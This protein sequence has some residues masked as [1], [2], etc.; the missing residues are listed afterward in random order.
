M[1]GS[2]TPK[3]YNLTPFSIFS[4]FQR[5]TW[6]RASSWWIR[7]A[8][9]KPSAPSW[10]A[11]TSRTR[12]WRTPTPT[13]AR[14]PAACT[15]WASCCTSRDIR[16]WGPSDIHVCSRIILHAGTLICRSARWCWSRCF[17]LMLQKAEDIWCG[18]AV[19]CKC[20]ER[21]FPHC[22]S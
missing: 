18:A 5:P 19:I 7:V 1:I 17:N 14:S 16:R 8:W 3:C 11:P 9:M 10:P 21:L 15:T 2:F 13:R 4:P 6:T 12:T 20:E 22:S